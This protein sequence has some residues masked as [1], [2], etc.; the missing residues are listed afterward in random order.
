[1]NFTSWSEMRAILFC[2]R[3]ADQKQSSLTRTRMPGSGTFAAGNISI[4]CQ[5]RRG[6]RWSAS[7]PTCCRGGGASDGEGYRRIIFGIQRRRRGILQAS[8]A[9]RPRGSDKELHLSGRRGRN[10]SGDQVRPPGERA[11][12]GAIADR[13]VPRHVACNLRL[14]RHAGFRQ[15]VSGRRP[16]ARLQ[17]GAIGRHLR[18]PLGGDGGDW[19]GAG[20][21]SRQASDAVG[22]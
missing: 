3:C 20:A 9:D 16:L 22:R 4:P 12:R 5:G 21:P 7:Q 13:R 15:L 10:R 11:H 19:Q 8:S 14:G 1:M 2:T 17:T 18:P 6:R